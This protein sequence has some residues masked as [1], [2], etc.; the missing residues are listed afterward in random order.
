MV[1]F[2]SGRASDVSRMRQGAT[3]LGIAYQT[4]KRHIEQGER[5]CSGHQRW[6]TADAFYASRDSQRNT[7][8]PEWKRAYQREKDRTRAQRRAS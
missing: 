5:W 4:Y 2:T 7:N 6:H 3:R 1:S 8:C